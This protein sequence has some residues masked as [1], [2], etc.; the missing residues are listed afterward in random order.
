MTLTVRIRSLIESTVYAATLPLRLFVRAWMAFSYFSLLFASLANAIVTGLS[1]APRKTLIVAN[2]PPPPNPSC[3]TT[4]PAHHGHNIPSTPVPKS[5]IPIASPPRYTASLDVKSPRFP[6]SLRDSPVRKN[7]PK[8]E[9]V[10]LLDINE[11]RRRV[12]SGASSTASSSATIAATGVN[13]RDYFAEKLAAK[14]MLMEAQEGGKPVVNR[15]RA[16]STVISEARQ[17]RLCED[18]AWLL[19]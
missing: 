16:S 17:R 8:N 4:L 5:R 9:V 6:A 18:L 15:R 1:P 19:E 7:D 11:R 13:P 2:P 10:E 3:V 12:S 14:M